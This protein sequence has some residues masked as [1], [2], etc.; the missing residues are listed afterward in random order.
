MTPWMLTHLRNG[1]RGTLTPC[2]ARRQRGT[3]P[4]GPDARRAPFSALAAISLAVLASAQ[5]RES[6]LGEPVRYE[7][8]STEQPVARLANALE[9]GTVT[10]ARDEKFGLL[11]SVLAALGVLP[12]SQTLVF[13]KTS[14][15]NAL[16]GPRTPRAIYFS[17][18]VYVGA[19]PGSPVLELTAMDPKLGPIFYT[20]TDRGDETPRIVRRDAECLRC[21]ALSWTNDWPGH[22][23]RSVAVDPDGHP[24]QR[25]GAK[26]T[27]GESPFEER[28]GG[29]YVTGTHGDAMHRGNATHEE[30]A[31]SAPP[32][33]EAQN[34]VDLR[35]HIDVARYLSPHSDLVAL[36]VLEHQSQAHNALA[37]A[38]GRARLLRHRSPEGLSESGRSQ[39]KEL[40]DDLLAVLLLRDVPPLPAPVRGT[41]D[42]AAAYLAAGPR[43][44][45]GNS[46]RELE[47]DTRLFRWPVSPTI[48]SPS[49]R[50]LPTE[51]REIVLLRMLRILTGRNGRRAYAHVAEEDRQ[52]LLTMLVELV[53]DLPADWHAAAKR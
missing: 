42:F 11:P 23:V 15:Q 34:L 39:L 27:T 7:R 3:S 5:D 12:A 45:A 46:L 30:D 29:W 10:L 50:H 31:E 51:L 53:P 6:Y 21:H 40:A 2:G 22:L 24:I 8:E 9:L 36:L 38:A 1:G 41:S 16:I 17:D 4:P 26:L 49:F 37:W 14:F 43:D 33:P 19:V 28:W 47:L 25:L 18:E 44:A 48:T 52:P 35:E 13:S 20:L 32:R